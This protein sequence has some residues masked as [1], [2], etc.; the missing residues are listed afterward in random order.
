MEQAFV[1]WLRQRLPGH[2]RLS[3]GPGDDA[4]VLVPRAG[5]QDVVTSDLLADGVH[6]HLDQAGA[7]RVGR[8][9][10]AVN[11]SDLAAMAAHP[12][13]AVVSLLLPRHHAEKIGPQLLEGMLPLVETFGIAIAGG[14]TNTW[15]GKLVISV[16]AFGEVDL[17]TG[18][19]LRRGARPGDA[20]IVTGSF[21]GSLMGRQFDFI[22][23]VHEVL[24]LRK[25]F[26]LNAGIDVS[27]GLSL[28]LWRMCQESG[29]GAVIDTAR[30]PVSDALQQQ[31]PGDENVDRRLAHALGDGED[32]E[33]ILAV[34]ARDA[35][36]MAKDQAIP[37]RLTQIGHFVESKGLWQTSADGS[38]QPLPVCGYEHV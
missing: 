26:Q 32:F 13:A 11:L 37:V 35:E 23:R 7:Q 8:K 31:W 36:R 17:D 30:I 20:I 18:P 27:D 2:P 4:A 14:D 16:T 21:G 5:M 3:V 10:L 38:L 15:D 1:R 12:V 34:P 6:F 25:R 19:L 22:P 9:A 24:A 33:L 29:C 28:D